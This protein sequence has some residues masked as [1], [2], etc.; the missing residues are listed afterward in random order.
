MT[1]KTKKIIIL[2]LILTLTSVL[3]SACGPKQPT[4]DIEAQKTSFALT[5]EAQASMTQAAQ[6]TST[7]TL[8][9]TMTPTA[10]ETQA[11]EVATPTETVPAAGTPTATQSVIT[12]NDA[13]QWIAQDPADNTEF[14]PGAVFTVTWTIEN[15]GTSTWTTNYYIKFTSDEQMDAEEKVYLPYPVPPGTNVQVSV[16]FKAPSSAG[17]YQSTWSL[18]NANDVAFYSNFYIIINVVE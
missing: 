16:E 14:A 13:G 9:P 15:T 5:A 4:I 17:E 11:V 3:F 8:E 10:T 2:T 7:P 1:K 18:V 6:P 12:G